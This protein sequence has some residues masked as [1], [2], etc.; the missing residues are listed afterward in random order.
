MKGNLFKFII[1]LFTLT[2][3]DSMFR[4]HKGEIYFYNYKLLWK[5]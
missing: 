3:I 5:L 2:Y 4:K 1:A